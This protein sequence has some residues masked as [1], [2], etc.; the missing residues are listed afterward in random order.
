MKFRSRQEV[1]QR[2]IKLFCH[3]NQD[4]NTGGTATLFVHYHRTWADMQH[5]GEL[6]LA[7]PGGSSENNNSTG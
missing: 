6:G 2:H 4:I 3:R 5:F 1:I 7:Q